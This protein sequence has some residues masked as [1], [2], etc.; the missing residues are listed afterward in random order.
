MAVSRPR[1]LI[2]VAFIDEGE[3]VKFTDFVGEVLKGQGLYFG[4]QP[5]GM[6]VDITPEL[7]E[8]MKDYFETMHIVIPEEMVAHLASVLGTHPFDVKSIQ[9]CHVPGVGYKYDKSA[10]QASLMTRIKSKN[11]D[12]GDG[13]EVIS[14][15]AD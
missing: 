12:E 3:Y 2:S 6:C 13:S 1:N 7:Y 10:F 8:L 14:C 11:S 15:G 5:M 4:S 9:G